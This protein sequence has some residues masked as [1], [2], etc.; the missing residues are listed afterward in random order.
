MA[1]LAAAGSVNAATTGIVRAAS[2]EAAPQGALGVTIQLT[3]QGVAAGDILDLQGPT[4]GGQPAIAVRTSP[5]QRIT[6]RRARVMV[7]VDRNAP[8]GIYLYTVS[9]ISSGG[10]GT[11]TLLVGASGSLTAPV[12]VSTAAIVYPPQGTVHGR[13]E[14][15]RP[16]G[17][18]A[19]TGSGP[20]TGSWLLDG[21]PFD[22]FT[23]LARGGRP[24]EVAARVP[25]PLT[26]DGAHALTLRI[27]SPQRV[28]SEPI[29]LVQ[30]ADK[31]PLM[32]LV[33]PAPHDVVRSQGQPP[34]FRWTPQPGAEGYELLLARRPEDSRDARRFRS[35]GPAFTVPEEIWSTLE[36][37]RWYW[38]ARPIFP[39]RVRG[40]LRDWIPVSLVK[41]SAG[42]TRDVRSSGGECVDAGPADPDAT[43]GQRSHEPAAD[44]SVDT[45]G[46]FEWISGNEEEEIDRA[47]A[48]LSA[49][50]S[51][52]EERTELSG[53]AD[54]AFQAEFESD[55][56]ATQES[57]G[58]AAIAKYG[59]ERWRG[60]VAAGYVSPEASTLR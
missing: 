53:A 23:V 60:T 2:R 20:L 49:T 18:L 59:P 41:E 39:G 36:P 57:R 10:T 42:T 50:L 5:L 24:V 28:D 12:G 58:Y 46:Q 3:F 55:G 32:R 51:T 13:G 1:V 14:Q 52:V 56:H 8:P 25:V 44:W 16:R 17:L 31:K 9:N 6:S 47:L 37:G 34:T 43:A 54:L 45:S 38:S 30:T 15:L 33:A 21:V 26:N 11:F 35:H 22:R 48:N 4:F 19:V 7:S 40:E 27:D 29:A